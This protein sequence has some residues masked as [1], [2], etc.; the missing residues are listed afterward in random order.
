[1]TLP[2]ASSVPGAAVIDGVDVGAVAAAVLVCPGVA[3]LD[4]GQ[5]GEVA[6][7]LP[8][9]KVAGV[10]V[11][12][13]RVKVQVRVRWAVPAPDLGRKITAA[14]VPLTG[15][16]PVDVVIADIDDPPGTL[17]A[18]GPRAWETVPG[19]RA[20]SVTARE[21]SVSFESGCE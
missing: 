15:H 5:F 16:Y 14:L 2:S 9:R 20:A 8:G 13:G 12:G 21:V 10:M 19:P 18:A 17:E 4:S 6:S 3:A 1:M 7:Y 11:S